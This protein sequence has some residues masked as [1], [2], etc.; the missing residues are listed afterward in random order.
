MTKLNNHYGMPFMIED[1]RHESMGLPFDSPTVIKRPAI[2]AHTYDFYLTRTIDEAYKYD[3]WIMV[4]EEV[5]E[6]DLI[7]VHIN[8][9]GGSLETALQIHD[10]LLA[11]KATVHIQIEGTC[12]SGASIIAMAGHRHFVAPNAY[13]MILSG[14]V[15]PTENSEM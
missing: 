10:A 4:C 14:Q 7:T 11:T 1:E 6:E 3:A 2:M 13:M 9:F 15:E 5:G 8:S 12:C